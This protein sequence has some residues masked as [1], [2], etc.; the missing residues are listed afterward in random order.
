MSIR[1]ETARPVGTRCTPECRTPRGTQAHCSVCHNTMS[2]VTFF[3][4]HRRDGRCVDPALLGLVEVD[5]LWFTPEGH[6]SRAVS[7]ARLAALRAA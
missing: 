3:D 4:A 1:P 7:A 5:G 6:E 2:G